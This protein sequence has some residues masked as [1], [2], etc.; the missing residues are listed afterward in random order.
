M[1]APTSVS[2]SEKAYIQSSLHAPDALR[3][4]GRSLKDFRNV[5]LETGAAPLANGSARVNLGKASHESGG[6]TEVIAAVKLEVENVENG[7]GV[8]GGRIVCTVLC[9]PAAYPQLSSNAL[10]E[11]QYDYTAVLHQTLSHPTLRPS[12]LGILPRKKSWLLNLDITIVSDAGN[13]Y[14]VMFMAARAALW[15]TKVP[16]T[17]SV[18]YAARKGSAPMIQAGEASMDVD[19]DGVPKSGFDTRRI[20]TATDFE[21]P[22]FW[23]EGEVLK[24][25]ELWPVCITLNIVDI[26]IQDSPI[27]YLDATPAEEVATPLKLL[28]MFSFLAGAS[29]NLQGMRL[30]GPGEAQL[31]QLKNF[32]TEGET[33]AKELFNALEAKLR[34]EDVRR[35]QKARDKFTLR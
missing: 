10:D 27:Y 31:V 26:L 5:F 7:D 14:D 13:T 21:L 19:E 1:T 34:D 32:I 30:L 18:Q 11:L 24:G 33:Y 2:K 8:D 29:P 3:A 9:S 35:N 23:D 22:D 25:R 28:L 12:N 16:R 17:R 15:D 4:D 6:G 20:P